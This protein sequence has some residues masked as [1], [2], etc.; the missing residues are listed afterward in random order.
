MAT[1]TD[2]L[3]PAIHHAVS[4][5][6]R[7]YALGLLVLVGTCSWTD[8]QLFSILL[9]P[10]KSA[11]GLS[12]TQLGLVGGTAFGLF[13][14]TVGLPVAWLADRSNRRNIVAIATG[15]WSVMTALTG[16]ATGFASLFLC[17]M[18]VGIGEAGSAAPSQSLVSDYFSVRH[19]ALAMGVLYSYLPIGYLLSYSLG[20]VLSD[21]IGWRNAFFAFGVPGLLLALVVRFTI[22]EPGQRT[23]A[24]SAGQSRHSLG[25]ALRY[26]LSHRSLRHMPLAGALHGIGMFGL[27]VWMPAYM[28]RAY[29]MSATGVGIR[30]AL[31]MGIAGM[32]GTLAG[33][34][35]VDRIVAKT[36]DTR[37][38]AY[39]C[40]AALLLS[41]P[42]TLSVFLLAGDANTATLL[43]VVPMILNHMILG[44][45]VASVQ[46]LAG[47]GRRAM[48]AAF[49]L[50]L[51]N[52]LSASLGPL[53]V[54]ALSDLIGSTSGSGGDSLRYS[55][56]ILLPLTA[57]WAAVHYF[58]AAGAIPG[59]LKDAE[60]SG[61]ASSIT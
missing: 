35:L 6:R 34:Q 40:A 50:F 54:G 19:R 12:D 1:P 2:V 46:N 48:G 16:F 45:A 38:Y 52:L 42:F 25:S 10:I 21:S 28:M 39:T 41:L 11:F 9:Q 31:T 27:A 61:A 56:S 3:A 30:L 5:N 57:S 51:V 47:A 32:I 37:W 36:G 55:L 49:Y 43:F 15:V 26:F 13:Y 17:R 53:F 20:G 24:A 4:L 23:R 18:G 7:L 8:R 60:G 22:A 59:D 14:V 58:L 29:H 33:G 44:P